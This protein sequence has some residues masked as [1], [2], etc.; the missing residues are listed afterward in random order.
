[1]KI[2]SHL[3]FWH[4]EPVKDAW[5]TDEMQVIK[6]DFM[7]EQLIPLLAKNGIDA[8]IAVQADQSENET[9][10]LLDLAN[11][12]DFIKGV[13]GWIDLRSERIEERL[14]YFSQFKLLKGFR[15]IVQ[16]EPQIDFLLRP[17]FCRGIAALA[18]YDYTYDILIYPKHIPYAL[19]F[20]KQFPNQR[21]VLDHLAK[22][23]IKDGL[24][25]DWA[26]Q[27]A[28]F[29]PMEHVS[30][31]MAGLITEANWQNWQ[32]AD[33]MRYVDK[34]L[35]IFGPDRMMYGSDWPVCL[36]AGSYDQVYDVVEKSIDSLTPAEK[37][38]ILGQTCAEYYKI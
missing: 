34:I 36:V 10:F 23:F 18:R 26:Q 37:N 1:M 30:C 31:K 35:E 12:Y 25:D 22:P 33:F 7:P 38:Q 2:D 16:A 6:N 13:V 21:F 9:H 17:D 15:H 3:H 27:I 4:Y 20:A 19:E 5:I 24:I 8:G 28:G 14:E 32:Q 11:Q 29:A